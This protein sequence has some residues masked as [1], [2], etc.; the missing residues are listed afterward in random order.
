M[1]FAYVHK[2][3]IISFVTYSIT[4]FSLK[5]QKHIKTLVFVFVFKYSVTNWLIAK[6]INFRGFIESV[7]IL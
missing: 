4:G 3:Y 7:N 6:R 1:W 5:T 2:T